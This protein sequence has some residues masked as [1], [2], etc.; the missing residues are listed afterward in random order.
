[1]YPVLTFGFT[2]VE[3][4][5]TISIL[6]V[7]MFATTSGIVSLY[8]TN[9]HTIAQTYEIANG[10]RGMA[11]LVRDLR[12]MT[13]GDDGTYPLVSMSSSSIGFY[14]DIDRDN[15]V[16]YVRYY[17][18]ST[19]LYKNVYNATGTPIGYSSTTPDEVYIISEYVRNF[20]QATSTFLYYLEDGVR[21]T[22]TSTVTDIRYIE[23]TMIIN[24]DPYRTP[25]E[26]KLTSSA[27][28]SNLK[29]IF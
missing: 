21:A 6:T 1:M 19:T 9:A 18:A 11:A 20:E 26:F 22:A 7:L 10:R 29:K 2:L 16:E 14:S 17:L 23:V 24:V 8:Q 15:S 5:V 4:L 28:P 12:E 25:G 27:A 13:F 3:T